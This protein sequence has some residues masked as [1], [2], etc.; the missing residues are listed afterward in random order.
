[1]PSPT[2]AEGPRRGTPNR[3]TGPTE[4]DAFQTASC[5]RW[6][7]CGR[8]QS[9]SRLYTVGGW[10]VGW[11]HRPCETATANRHQAPRSVPVAHALDRGRLRRPGLLPRAS[12]M[13]P[14]W[15]SMSFGF[16][17]PPVGA[18]HH[19]PRA[20]LLPAGAEGG[21][22]YSRTSTRP[23]AGHGSRRARRRRVGL[24]AP[25]ASHKAA[26]A[27]TLES[28]GGGNAVLA[29]VPAGVCQW[30]PRPNAS[31]LIS[32]AINRIWCPS[33]GP[34]HAAR[35]NIWPRAARSRH[36]LKTWV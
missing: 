24:A 36:A 32:R 14:H 30:R 33:C 26:G 4:K 20:C 5:G 7:R 9:L 29:P 3:T 22:G 34:R 10:E 2:W 1:M 25:S 31:R 18:N 12:V 11:G 13:V 19:H 15:P 8:A 27:T 6:P 23:A 35:R 17:K 21:R 16:W 28:P